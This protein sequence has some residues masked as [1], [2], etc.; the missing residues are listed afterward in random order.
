MA[1]VSLGGILGSVYMSV[2]TDVTRGVIG[3][4]GAPFAL[5]LPRSSDFSALFS[6][7]DARYTDPLGPQCIFCGFCDS[8]LKVILRDTDRILLVSQLQLLW[9]RLCPRFEFVCLFLKSHR[10][11]P[12][13]WCQRSGWIHHLSRDP[14]PNTPVHTVLFQYSLGD[15]QVSWLG[16][17]ILARSIGASMFSDNVHYGLRI[18]M[19]VF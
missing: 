4:G 1:G 18:N 16:G 7:L 3:V 5:L 2:T 10:V 17:A 13:N 11:L 9:D 12:Y 15:A 19:Q 6:V 8:V 14:L